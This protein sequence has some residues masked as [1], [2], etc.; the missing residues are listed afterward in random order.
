MR[1]VLERQG[2]CVKMEGGVGGSTHMEFHIPARGL[3]GLRTR[4]LTATN[5]TAI[6]HHNFLDYRPQKASIPG[7]SNGVLISTETAKATSYAIEGLQDR[8]ILFV[9]PMEPVYEG[10]IVGEHNRDND[11]PVN[12]TREKKLTNIRSATAE[13]KTVLKQPMKFSLEMALEY[14]DDDELVEI[15]PGAIRLRKMLLKESDRKRYERQR[16]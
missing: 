13:I 2:E 14:I 8:G 12:V 3:I 4:M 5:G 16:V 10:Q 6:M 15:T 7:R 1:L 9:A 11:L